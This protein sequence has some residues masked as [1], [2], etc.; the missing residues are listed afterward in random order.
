MT[1][2]MCDVATA[3]IDDEKVDTSKAINLIGKA[4]DEFPPVPESEVCVETLDREQI[5]PPITRKDIYRI[6]DN[7]V[8]SHINVSHEEPAASGCV[9]TLE[10]KPTIIQSLEGQIRLLKAELSE[11][12]KMKIDISEKAMKMLG[13]KI[14][15]SLETNIPGVSGARIHLE[16]A[17]KSSRELTGKIE[18][19]P[20]CKKCNHSCNIHNNCPME[21][22]S[23]YDGPTI[24]EKI[25]F[26]PIE[27]ELE[28]GLVILPPSGKC[29]VKGSNKYC[30]G[31][32]MPADKYKD[33]MISVA[34]FTE[35]D[36]TYWSTQG[37]GHIPIYSV[38]DLDKIILCTDQG[39]KTKNV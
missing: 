3:A 39:L 19:D 36:I 16:P 10:H 12:R 24:F 1:T 28:A 17:P 33:F 15:I 11:E 9:E 7:A 37:G 23:C 27:Q 34:T 38:K 4:L 5:K 30:T 29:W 32:F 35:K 6:V 31:I 26:S 13:D 8:V 18:I 20:M 2:L 22:C 21:S 14:T 25:E